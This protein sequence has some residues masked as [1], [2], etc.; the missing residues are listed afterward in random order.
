MIETVLDGHSGD[1]FL[2]Q[3]R[4]VYTPD[5]SGTTFDDYRRAA[6]NFV[7]TYAKER[8]VIVHTPKENFSLNLFSLALFI[9][10]CRMENNIDAAVFK[11][12]DEAKALAEY[13]P[14]IALTIAVKYVMRLCKEDAA[15]I[16]HEFT[17]MGY[18]GLEITQD[19]LKD[20]TILRLK[21]AEDLVRLTPQST[22]EAVAN[23]AMLK[24]L[25]L[26]KGGAN[27]EVVVKNN[28]KDTALDEDAA[29]AQ[30]LKDI[31]PWVK[32]G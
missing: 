7:K 28:P 8:I 2:N 6:K 29:I 27:I 22:Q 30:I 13:R 10:S 19:Y 17:E 5:F 4:P 16:Y 32:V 23:V 24:A 18:L 31:T 9:E 21:G 3:P 26:L 15:R 14:F 20:E 1:T 25:S 12:A 11:V